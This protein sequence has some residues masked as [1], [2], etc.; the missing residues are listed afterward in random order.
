MPDVL[1]MD[2]INSLPQ[3]ILGRDLGTGDWWWPINDF[4][5]ESGMCRIDVMGRLQ[6]RWV[7]DFSVFRD[8]DGVEHAP[9]SLFLEETCDD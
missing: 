2:F 4:E 3:P 1:R 8:A 6:P 9:D 5:V 7:I